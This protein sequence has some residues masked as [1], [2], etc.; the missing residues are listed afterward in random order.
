V[1]R[2]VSTARDITRQKQ[3]EDRLEY[4]G[5]YDPLTGIPNRRYFADLLTFELGER[6]HDDGRL[7]VMIM[8]IDRFKYINDLFGVAV[9]DEVLQRIT[10]VLKASIGEHD[11]VAAW[12]ATSSAWSTGTTPGSSTRP[13]LRAHPAGGL[14]EDHGGRPGYRDDRHDRIASCPSTAR[15]C[16]RSS[17][18]PTWRCPGPRRRTQRVLFYHKT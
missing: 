5:T 6:Q 11:V 14:A 18:A 7:A 9:G 12:A 10:E 17:S 2:F 1:T 15:T 13:E 16:E 4:L 3:L 8:D